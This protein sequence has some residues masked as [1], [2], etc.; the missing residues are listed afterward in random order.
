MTCLLFLVS[1]LHAQGTLA[2]YQRAHDLRS[3]ARDLVVNTPGPATW[4]GDSEHFW[5]PKTVKGGTEFVLVDAEAGS[6][7][8][9]FDQDKLAAA[10][11]TATGNKYAGLKLPFAPMQGRPG[12]RPTPDNAP[13]TAPLTFLDG[14]RSIQFGVDGSLYKCNLSDYTCAKGGPIPRGGRPDRNAAPEDPSL[15]NPEDSLEGRGGDPVDGLEYQPPAPQDGDQEP[16]PGDRAGARRPA[17]LRKASPL[18]PVPL[19]PARA[20]RRFLLTSAHRLTASTK[21]SSKT[22]TSS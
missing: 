15:S 13:A 18:R 5:Y 3:K 20:A 4:I 17:K 6:K 11:S 22:S 12:A 19:V 10:I 1:S 21:P 9:A 16:L 2:D 8:P 7:K 14:E